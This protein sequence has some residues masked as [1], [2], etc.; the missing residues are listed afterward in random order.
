MLTLSDGDGLEGADQRPEPATL[1]DEAD[2]LVDDDGWESGSVDGMQLRSGDDDDDDDDETEEEEEEEEVE[3]SSRQN[4]K[5]LKP[6]LIL[7]S[8]N[9]SKSAA[10]STFLP[11]LSVGYIKG[12]SD[13]DIEPSDSETAANR[14]KNRRGQRARQASVQLYLPMN[15][16]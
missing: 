13:S 3:K 7:E 15:L 4:S 12:D 1:I 9:P 2:D 10:S 6:S 16:C 14:K 8:L 5:Q 11:S